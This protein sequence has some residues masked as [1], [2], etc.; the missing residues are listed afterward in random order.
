MGELEYHDKKVAEAHDQG[1]EEGLKEAGGSG[2]GT[3]GFF[4]V[5]ILFFIGIVY[6][7]PNGSDTSGRT[8]HETSYVT[9]TGSLPP[10]IGNYISPDTVRFYKYTGSGGEVYVRH[11]YEPTEQISKQG[12]YRSDTKEYILVDINYLYEQEQCICSWRIYHYGNGNRSTVASGNDPVDVV[13]VSS[14]NCQSAL[15]QQL[16]AYGF[17]PVTY[18]SSDYYGE[19]IDRSTAFSI[20]GY[21]S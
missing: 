8:V 5:L 11:H 3:L 19:D 9:Q 7:N 20:I 18:N 12:Y 21:A 1:K 4:L 10:D 13:G 17:D 2:D 15:S 14:Y 16:E 6:F